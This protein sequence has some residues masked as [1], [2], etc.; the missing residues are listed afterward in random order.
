MGESVQKDVLAGFIVLSCE[1]IGMAK[2]LILVELEV[3]LYKFG[4]RSA[5]IE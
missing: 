2:S 1:E 5:V 4:L 3:H